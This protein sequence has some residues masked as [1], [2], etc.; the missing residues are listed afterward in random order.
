MSLDPALIALANEMAQ[1]AGSVI[2]RY[3][4]TPVGVDTKADESPVTIADREAEL[5]MRALLE[6]Q[7]PQD[8]VLGEEH[9]RERL[10]AEY[11]W[12]LDPI[13]GTKAFITGMPVFG[14]LIGL[15]HRG[16][17][18]LG[19]IDQPISGERWLG[20]AGAVT[21]LNGQRLRTRP[22]PSLDKAFLYSTAPDMFKGDDAVAYE[23]VRTRVRQPRFGGDCYAYGL[24]AMGF[25]DLVI[26]ASLQ[27]YDYCAVIPVIEGA[28]GV[29]T[30]WQGK[31]L[32]IESDGRVVAA[33]DRAAH[34]A[35]LQALAG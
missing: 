35:A 33:G 6:R 9:G 22:C 2:R 14:T 1:A 30:D 10:E 5:A 13:D 8:G 20:L 29:M 24:V 17:P 21:T 16:R 25:A 4:R 15:L 12:V 27:P 7:R 34:A 28:G 19:I 32:T 18:A 23:R 26:E 31:P 11:V 3:F